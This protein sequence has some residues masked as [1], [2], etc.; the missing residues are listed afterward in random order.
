[1][2]R[3]CYILLVLATCHS[4]LKGQTTDT[5]IRQTTKKPN[6]AIR[7]VPS[8]L[9]GPFPSYM[10]A[11]EHALDEKINLEYVLGTVYD[12]RFGSDDEQYFIDKR[13]FK[14][15]VRLKFYGTLQQWRVYFALEGFFSQ[16]KFD[17]DRTF[18]LACGA[19]C[20][21]FERRRYLI[22]NNQFGLRWYGGIQVPVTRRIYFELEFAM[23]LK[24]TRFDPSNFPEEPI[25]IF[26][27][28]FTDEE[29]RLDLALN[30]GFS[31]AYRLK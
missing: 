20:S 17:R 26:G 18:E 13:G 31:L 30:A 6:L 14:S 21:F 23:G 19:D 16:F 8:Q 29:S 3:L 4:V 1:M 7:W 25:T 15:A 22:T 2:K 24:S 27:R 9:F 10:F 12:G 28:P 5:L 11:V